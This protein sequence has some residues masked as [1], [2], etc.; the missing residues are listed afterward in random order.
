MLQKQGSSKLS[1]IVMMI[2]PMMLDY[3]F[4][5]G[6]PGELLVSNPHCFLIASIGGIDYYCIIAIVVSVEWN[7]E[8]KSKDKNKNMKKKMILPHFNQEEVIE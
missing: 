4:L 8:I 2:Y 1:D 5:N 6:L 3:Q 7:S